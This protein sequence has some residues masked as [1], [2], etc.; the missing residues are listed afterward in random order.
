MKYGYFLLE[1]RGIREAKGHVEVLFGIYFMLREVILQIMRHENLS[2]FFEV[3]QP[4]MGEGV[5]RGSSSASS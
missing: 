3:D 2:E 5:L 1:E 4:C